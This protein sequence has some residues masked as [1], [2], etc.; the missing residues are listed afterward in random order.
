[1]LKSKTKFIILLI[2]LV[3]GITFVTLQLLK[4]DHIR[5]WSELMNG[6]NKSKYEHLTIK[7]QNGKISADT[8]PDVHGN[9]EHHYFMLPGGSDAINSFCATLQTFSDQGKID[10]WIVSSK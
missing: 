6:L 8:I 1:M 3:I 9:F 7:V 2:T 5:N 4:E 10:S